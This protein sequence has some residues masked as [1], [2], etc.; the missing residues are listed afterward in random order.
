MKLTALVGTK[1]RVELLVV[2]DQQAAAQGFRCEVADRFH[3]KYGGDSQGSVEYTGYFAADNTG[4][5]I[6][7]PDAALWLSDNCCVTKLTADLLPAQMGDDVA[8]DLVPFAAHRD[9]LFSTRAR[10]KIIEMI[11]LLGALIGL[12]LVVWAFHGRRM[13]S[14]AAGQGVGS[15]GCADCHG[16]GHYVLAIAC[17]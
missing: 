8:I 5:N 17:D 9:H 6:G 3:H 16:D 11:L 7:N 4:L 10:W 1:T 12:G 14:V 2:A 13:P 15:V